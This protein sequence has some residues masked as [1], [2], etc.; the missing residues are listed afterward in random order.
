[1]KSFKTYISE[2]VATRKKPTRAERIDFRNKMMDVRYSD[3][4]DKGERKKGM[5]MWHL[6]GHNPK[7]KYGSTKEIEA[8]KERVFGKRRKGTSDLLWM[9]HKHGLVTHPAIGDVT[10]SDIDHR[11]GDGV[12]KG[13]K[14]DKKTQ[15]KVKEG[16]IGAITGHGRIEHHEGGGGLISYHHAGGMPK[17]AAIRTISRAYPKYKIHDGYGN[18]LE[19]DMKK[20]WS[21]LLKSPAWQKAPSNLTQWQLTGHNPGTK[22]GTTHE[23]EQAKERV[24]GKRKGN[25]ELFWLHGQ[26]GIVTHPAVGDITHTDVDGPASM[27]SHHRKR[28]GIKVD[29]SIQK[30]VIEGGIGSHQGL[31]RIEHHEGGGGL[32]SYHHKGGIS[33]SAAVRMIARLYP[34]H[35]IHD[36]QGNLLENWSYAHDFD[37]MP[38]SEKQ[39]YVYH[40]TTAARAAKIVKQ[41][42]KPRT[43]VQRTNYPDLSDH[44]RGH[45]FITNHHGVR[46]WKDQ[47]AV[48]VNRRKHEVSEKDYEN[49]HVVKFPIANMKKSTRRKLRLDSI[50]TKDA[51][52]HDDD[53]VIDPSSHE[54]STALK[55]RK[56]INEDVQ[57]KSFMRYI[58]EAKEET[59][60]DFVRFAAR[61]LG[62]QQEPNIEFV[63]VRDGSM[64]T[65]A[66]S[67]SDCSMKI[68]RGNRAT[69]DI[70]RSIA[71]EMV[72]QMQDEN[73]DEL[74]GTTGSPC[75]DEANAV[76]GRLIRM[77]GAEN[78]SFYE[79]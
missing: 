26:H 51:R 73:G 9:H 43:G 11:F 54:A 60:T 8:T 22:R 53:P 2:A 19:S 50:G 29:K 14:V 15:A 46:Y 59:I 74:D 21:K 42:L 62:L 30:K 27:G 63:D 70:C 41:G 32:I 25:S 47:T 12:R 38:N 45:A 44:T 72:H 77:Y 55:I 6:T 36:G 75:E 4:F 61:E 24:F 35:Q 40:V 1:M 58:N 64:T 57:I 52:H 7:G 37:E 69:F 13:I 56:K 17:E 16:G 31:G 67:P 68:Y 5:H 39:K 28:K 20:K 48:A 65:A 66:Y 34:K 3:A 79:E 18:L 71:H 33:K 10:H 49:I 76:A 23:I 78:D